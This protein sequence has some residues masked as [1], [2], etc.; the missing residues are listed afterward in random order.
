MYITLNEKTRKCCHRTLGVRDIS[1]T[2]AIFNPHPV[3]SLERHHC[4]VWTCF[5]IFLSTYAS[6]CPDFCCSIQHNV[7]VNTLMIPTLDID[8]EDV[9]PR[10]G[11]S[12]Y[13][14]TRVVPVAQVCDDLGE[15]QCTAV[16]GTAAWRYTCRECYPCRQ[17]YKYDWI[18]IKMSILLCDSFISLK[19]N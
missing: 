13:P 16:P 2:D 18:I 12:E 9:Y 14:V 1:L 15:Y 7:H 17:I 6:Y 4:Q 5:A 10:P 8:K 3:S 19:T 11:S